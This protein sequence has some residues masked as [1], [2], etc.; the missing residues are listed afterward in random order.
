MM[1]TLIGQPETQRARRMTIKTRNP[2][3]IWI[4]CRRTLDKSW[5]LLCHPLT[6]LCLTHLATL[7]TSYIEKGQ[8]VTSET[9][10]EGTSFASFP[11]P[12]PDH[13]FTILIHFL[14]LFVVFINYFNLTQFH[15]LSPFPPPP[16]PPHYCSV[17][18]LCISPFTLPS[19]EIIESTTIEGR[20]GQRHTGKR[21]RY[22]MNP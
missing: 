16:P 1:S 6:I 5:K 21:Y 15:I 13:I 10:Q 11:F 7:S 3:D 2:L 22:R 14:V 8:R 17:V 20:Q 19:G 9:T 4:K 12:A 18:K